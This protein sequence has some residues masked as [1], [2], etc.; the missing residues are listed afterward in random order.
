MMMS[1]DAL[2][3]AEAVFRNTVQDDFGR[4]ILEKVF[5]PIVLELCAL[6]QLDEETQS[7]LC[8]I[9]RRAEEARLI[10]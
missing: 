6:E 2:R 7:I 8:E 3:M 4:S 10:V 5:S 9:D 1:L